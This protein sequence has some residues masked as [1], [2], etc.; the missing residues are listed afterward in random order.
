M[1]R[2][3]TPPSAERHPEVRAYWDSYGHSIPWEKLIDCRWRADGLYCV[4]AWD[5]GEGMVGVADIAG[6]GL[7]RWEMQNDSEYMTLKQWHGLK[8]VPYC[9]WYRVPDED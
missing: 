2:P 1:P 5:G 7:G 9:D 4:L 8:I 3:M 6:N